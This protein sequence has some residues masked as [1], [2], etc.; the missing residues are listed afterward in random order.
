MDPVSTLYEAELLIELRRRHYYVA[1]PHSLLG[2]YP[3]TPTAI[4]PLARALAATSDTNY[5]GGSATWGQANCDM[6][7]IWH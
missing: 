5:R 4:L 2:Y 3:P 7:F 6:E 1:T